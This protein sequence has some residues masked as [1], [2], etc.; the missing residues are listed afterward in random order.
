MKPVAVWPLWENKSA[1]TCCI[2]LCWLHNLLL[3]SPCFVRPYLKREIGG[4]SARAL[5]QKS[6]VVHSVF[7]ICWPYALSDVLGVECST[8][9]YTNISIQ[10][11]ITS[12]VLPGAIGTEV[13]HFLRNNRS[14]VVYRYVVNFSV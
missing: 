2:N 13:I 5:C 7:K 8:S 9:R 6:R 10:L 1:L 4:Q 11:L 3:Y 12:I 14:K